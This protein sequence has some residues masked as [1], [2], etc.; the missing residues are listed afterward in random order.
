MCPQLGE[1]KSIC[2]PLPQPSYPKFDLFKV[3]W[4]DQCWQWSPML[5]G[6]PFSDLK[7]QR[8]RPARRL[9]AFG[10]RDP[11][12]RH[13]GGLTPVTNKSSRPYWYRKAKAAQNGQLNPIKLST[14]III[15]RQE[16]NWNAWFFGFF[17]CFG[18][19]CLVSWPICVLSLNLCRQV[20]PPQQ[21]R[22]LMQAAF[23]WNTSDFGLPH[24]S[25][26]RTKLQFFTQDWYVQF[27]SIHG[28]HSCSS[29]F[30]RGFNRNVIK[31][32]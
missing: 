8:F 9:V 5:T 3:D 32:V 10:F 14:G 28:L 6:P 17:Y 27:A 23:Y 19:L 22:S 13:V 31:R 26:T 4:R 15:S 16:G 11:P 20:A 12:S 25:C 21:D 18:R 2:G 7:F 29:H 1:A 24:F 30:S